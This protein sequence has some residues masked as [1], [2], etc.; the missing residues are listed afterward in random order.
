MTTG[1]PKTLQLTGTVELQAAAAAGDGGQKLPGIRMVANTGREMRV[2][3]FRYPVVL[4][5]AGVQFDKPNSPFLMDHDTARRVGHATEQRVTADGI[6]AAGVVS[7]SSPDALSFVADSKA[8]FPFEASIGADILES[9]FIDVGKSE[10]V[11]GRTVDGPAVVAD[12][13]LVKEFTVC[14]LGADSRTSAIAAGRGGKK[15]LTSMNES[16][17]EAG[18]GTATLDGDAETERLEAISGILGEPGEYIF[19]RREAENLRAKAAAGQMKFKELKL[20]AKQLQNL[21]KQRSNYIRPPETEGRH[22]ASGHVGIHSGRPL[23]EETYFEAAASR[24]IFGSNVEKI[25]GEQVAYGVDRLAATCLLDVAKGFLEASGGEHFS[26]RSKEQVLRAAFSTASGLAV[27]LGNSADKAA[28]AAYQSL[29][30]VAPQVCR[31]VSA[32]NFRTHTGIKLDGNMR[33]LEVGSSGEL[34]HGE[35]AES[36]FSYRIATYGRMFTISRQDLI[37]DDLQMLESIPRIIAR[38]FAERIDELFAELLLAN[39]GNFFGESHANYLNEGS[40]LGIT[41]LGQAATLMRRQTDQFGK[42]VSVIPAILLCPPELEVTADSLFASENLIVAG[43]SDTILPSGNPA[44]GKYRPVVMPHL[45]NSGYSGYST[46][47]W[48]LLTNPSDVSPF[49]LAFLDGKKGPSV[50]SADANFDTLGISFR[51]FGDAGVAQLDY[52][53]GVLSTGAPAGE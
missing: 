24:L 43:D 16:E 18:D 33:F 52:R 26:F 13:S 25:Y 5:L 34:K 31:E 11:N 17:L 27:L 19:V 12:R 37:N 23:T 39:T 30:P 7:S 14:T 53:G 41:A 3:G 50:E 49:A 47:A 6:F 44:R 29:T 48:W 21:E 45:S 10:Q 32:S 2:A 42:P 9:H 36:T 35:L 4:K 51:G 46:T 28:L 22:F 15:G 20:R 1:E 8:G 40:G 38:A